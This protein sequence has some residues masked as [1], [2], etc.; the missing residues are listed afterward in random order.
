MVIL[1]QKLEDRTL[2]KAA[3]GGR[4]EGLDYISGRRVLPIRYLS[5]ERAAC[6]PS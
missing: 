4:V 5:I 3:R 2:S 1:R 6:L